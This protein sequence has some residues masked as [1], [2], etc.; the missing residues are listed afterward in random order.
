MDTGSQSLPPSSSS[1][2]LSV[3]INTQTKRQPVVS[4]PI[5]IIAGSRRSFLAKWYDDFTWLEYDTD[6]DADFC[7]IC[8][9]AAA[10]FHH[11]PHE[12]IFTTAGFKNWKK[13]FETFRQHEKSASHVRAATIHI[14]RL[15]NATIIDKVVEQKNK[16][17]QEALKC[18]HMIL[19]SVCYLARQGLAMGDKDHQEDGNLSQLLRFQAELSPILRD[20]LKRKTTWIEMS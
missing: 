11:Q 9:T 16:E 17:K 2:P 20:C 3:N 6:V 7:Y 4:F 19:A 12:P 10:K 5:T 18:L 8:R 14:S 13:A 1:I 15:K